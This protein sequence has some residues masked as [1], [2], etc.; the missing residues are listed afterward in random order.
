MSRA[1]LIRTI[2]CAAALLTVSSAC[3][4]EQEATA[5]V[6][7]DAASTR[8]GASSSAKGDRFEWERWSSWVASS[9]RVAE[10]MPFEFDAECARHLP[11]G[12]ETL[13]V[14]TSANFYPVSGLRPINGE[15]RNCDLEGGDSLEMCEAAGVEFD[16]MHSVCDIL[17]V[18][19]EFHHAAWGAGCC[20]FDG[21]DRAP[22]LEESE[23]WGGLYEGHFHISAA[24][25]GAKRNR[26]RVFT[27]ASGLFKPG[28][29]CG[30]VTLPDAPT[31]DH[32]NRRTDE[33][34]QGPT[35]FKGVRVGVTP[36]SN[37][38]A[39]TRD[40]YPDAEIVYGEDIEAL[41]G[42]L[43]AGEIDV[44]DVG[45]G[46][47]REKIEAGELVFVTDEEGVE[48]LHS[49]IDPEGETKHF[50]PG[51]AFYYSPMTS[52]GVMRAVDCAINRVRTDD[53]DFYAAVS[54]A[55]SVPESFR[56]RAA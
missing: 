23:L 37:F 2:C 4:E 26:I 11:Q 48:S 35:G 50:G 44:M 27:P 41:I 30:H 54:Q 28:L 24:A 42:L 3:V 9:N 10:T 56:R 7:R 47:V 16:A 14:G 34:D 45:I 5:P 36:S 53:R 51:G 31:Y 32:T 18:A 8:P 20:S 29:G 21:V 43:R 40:R 13:H 33:R 17:G 46:L 52:A 55:G 49:A 25:S 38:E 19:C 1:H 39:Y 22:T 15:A 6:V 12:F